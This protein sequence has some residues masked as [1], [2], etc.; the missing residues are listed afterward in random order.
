M[1]SAEFIKDKICV[2]TGGGSGI[3][4]A[5]CRRFA[6]LGAKKVIV[7]DLDEASAKKVAEGIDGIAVRCNVAQEMDVRR[8]I[9]VAEA[10]GP[11]DIFIANAGIPSNGGYEVPND[12][13]DRIL[14]VNVMQHVYV[15]RHLFPLWQKR[16]GDKYF[17]VTASAAGL[18]T[19]VGSLPYSVTKHAAVGLAEWYRITY[20]ENGIKVSCL[21][22]QA[23]ETG[24]IPK[25]SGG[26]VA[27]GDG[28]IQPEKVAQ[29]V[30]NAMSEGK[31]LILP[32]P[33]VLTYMQ[34][35]AA[36]YERW[37]TG[38][39]RLHRSFG[40]LVRRS[41]PISAAKL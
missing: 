30:V 5:L 27:G 26:G 35:K 17:V 12:E 4:A 25:G 15:A 33:E 2:V 21:C 40:D 20:A 8:L 7:A 22:P 3:G 9:S 39:G 19:Q 29:D 13:W 34:R 16:E 28:L 32:H 38:M 6:E 37:L 18:L 14:G 10:A 31:F 23:V 36:D 41:P 11:I 24:M 1:S